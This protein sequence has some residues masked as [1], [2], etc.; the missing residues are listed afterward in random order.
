EGKGARQSRAVEPAAD[1][2]ARRC[3]VLLNAPV[4]PSYGN[5]L[6]IGREGKGGDENVSVHLAPLPVSGQVPQGKTLIAAAGNCFSV[7]RDRAGPVPCAPQGQ[8]ADFLAGVDVP[9]N[10]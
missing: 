7:R 3:L 6:A 9:L 1:S 4:T 8:A 10:Q 5:P 2:L